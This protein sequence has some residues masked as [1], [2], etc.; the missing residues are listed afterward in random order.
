MKYVVTW[1]ER[2]QGSPE[3]Y[4][5]AQKRILQIFSDYEMPSTVNVLQFVVR[6]GS[7]SGYMVLET[8]TSPICTR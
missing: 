2:P 7:W 6:I 8:T 5:N 1:R 3:A 4:E